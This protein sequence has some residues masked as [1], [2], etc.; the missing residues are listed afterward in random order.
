MLV[1]ENFIFKLNKATSSTKYYRCNDP[2]CSVVVHTDLED[3]LLKIKDDHC[4][5]PEPEEVQIRT[6][7]QAV[8]TRAINET[9]H[10]PQIYDEEALRIDLSQLSIAAL[11]SQREMS[12]TLNKARRFQTP[13]IPDTQLFDLPECYTKTIK[14]LPFLCIDQLVKPF[15]CV[16][17]LLPDQKKPTYKFLLNG[18]RDKAAE[19]NMMFNPT[20]IM[21]DFE[22]SLVE[23]LKSEFPN[24]Q[25]CGCYF[26]HNQAI[27]RNIQKLGLSSTY[28]DDEQ[29]RIICRK[30]MA[31]ASLPLSLDIKAFDNL[32]D[33]VLES[34]STTFKLLEPLFTYFENQWIKAVEIKR[35]N[36]YGIQM[37][38]NNNC[39]GYHN[40]LNSRICKYHPNIWIFI[41]CI[42]GE[43][44]RFNHL[45]IQMKG[46]LAARPQTKTTQ[47]IQ[48]RIDNLYARYENKEVSP[49]ELLEG[50]SFV[51]AKNS[52][53][54][55]K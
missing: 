8:K 55:K 38:T 16:F 5:P 43:E 26:H 36:A 47:A 11:P 2:C 7:R 39:E 35:W 45:L 22:G 14:G 4:H 42:Q 17:A 37:R 48:K 3:N 44:N 24:S 9:T 46:S 31:L 30:L 25:H 27:Y 1:I 29:I 23:V 12:H 41:R 54:K 50:L 20:T 19:M 15:V 51:V 13:P 28:V 32:Y 6:F 10:I 34:S 53:S 18:L 52:K 40:R 49:D 21:S 33:S